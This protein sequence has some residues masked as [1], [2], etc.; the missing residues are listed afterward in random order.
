VGVS[1]SADLQ[2]LTQLGCDTGQG[3]LLG[4]PMT[5]LQLDALVA[6]F[7]SQADKRPEVRAS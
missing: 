2:L 3:F 5:A 1:T 7:L 4:K 6:G